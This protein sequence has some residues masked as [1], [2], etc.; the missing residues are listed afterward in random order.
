MGAEVVHWPSVYVGSILCLQQHLDLLDRL[1]ILH[2]NVWLQRLEPCA[3]PSLLVPRH[4]PGVGSC[5]EFLWALRLSQAV[6]QTE[7]LLVFSSTVTVKEEG[8]DV[9][10]RFWHLWWAG[11]GSSWYPQATW[12]WGW[13]GTGKGTARTLMRWDRLI[14]E[15]TKHPNQ[16]QTP[17]DAEEIPS[18]WK[19][20]QEGIPAAGQESCGQLES[21]ALMSQQPFA[22]TRWVHLQNLFAF[23][24]KESIAVGAAYPSTS[25]GSRG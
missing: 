17:G 3:C 23:T 12:H 21:T 5:C 1:G 24:Q 22:H 15:E 6:V 25:L 13:R 18:C 16:S 4:C 14:N 7:G 9:T 19:C 20:F 2:R 11:W 8:Q 10:Q